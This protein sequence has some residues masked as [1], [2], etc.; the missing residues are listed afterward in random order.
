MIRLLALPFVLAMMMVPVQLFAKAEA[1][2]ITIKGASLEAPIEITDE[3]ILANFSVW[4]GPGTTSSDRQSPEPQ[5]FIV[6]WSQASGGKPPKGMAQYEVSFY[7]K[8]PAHAMSRKE[9]LIYVV[10]YAYNPLTKR[11]Y[12]YLPGKTEDWYQL[13]TSAIVHGVE[14]RWFR[15]WD[16]WDRV[17][18]PLIE[19]ATSANSLVRR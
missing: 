18:A 8:L 11:G 9:R 19:K 16:A 10:F 12:V 7:A 6:D 13:N 3:R 4:T 1:S 2:R 5:S 15:A 17:A 14:G